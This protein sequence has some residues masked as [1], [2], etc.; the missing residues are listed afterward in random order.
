MQNL[1]ISLALGLAS[2]MLTSACFDKM[3]FIGLHW[4]AQKTTNEVDN[5]FVQTGAE[6]AGLKEWYNSLK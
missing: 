5:Q 2:K 6:A 1:L 3:I 4:I